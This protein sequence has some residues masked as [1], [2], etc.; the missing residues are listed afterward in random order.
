MML[1][2]G[3][4]ADAP[5]RHTRAPQQ[6]VPPVEEAAQIPEDREVDAGIQPDTEAQHA[7]D[8]A[9]IEEEDASELFYRRPHLADIIMQP[10]KQQ[11][12]LWHIRLPAR[13]MGSRARHRPM[14]LTRLAAAC[15]IALSRPRR[16]SPLVRRVMCPNQLLFFL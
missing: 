13:A 11:Q 15:A 6:A 14:L 16:S 10:Q 12:S 9:I 5:V 8:H 7:A 4:S 2:A 3:G 1:C